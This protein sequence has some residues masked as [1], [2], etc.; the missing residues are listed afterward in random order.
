MENILLYFL[1]LP[2]WEFIAVIL[3]ITYVVLVAQN[4]IWCWPAAFI[5]TLLFTIIFFDVA[6]LMESLLNVYYMAMAVFGWYKWQFHQQGAQY[7]ELPIQRWRISTHVKLILGLSVLSLSLG[8]VMDNYTHA[9]YAYL[10]TFT[11]VFAVFTTYLVTIKVIENWLYW[12]VINALSIYL[13]I[14]KGLHPTALL[15][16]IN[17]VMCFVGWVKWHQVFKQQRGDQLAALKLS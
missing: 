3:S 11:T 14:N 17:F 13:F 7:Q 12:M 8:F 5:S 1:N 10:D 4:N 6:L 2:F 9:D 15:A 16:F